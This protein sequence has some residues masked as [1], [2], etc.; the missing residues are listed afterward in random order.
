MPDGGP[1]RYRVRHTA[2]LWRK[3]E[4]PKLTAQVI[5]SDPKFSI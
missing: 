3:G 2:Q 5:E 1:L 4:A